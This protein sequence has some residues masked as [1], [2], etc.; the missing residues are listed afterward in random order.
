MPCQ[1]Q[2]DFARVDADPVVPNA[3]QPAAASLEFHLNAPRARVQRIFDELFNHRRGT[4]DNLAG[5]DLINE[6]IGQKLD[7]QWR[8]RRAF[9]HKAL[10]G[11][12]RVGLARW[13]KR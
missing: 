7:G 8:P 2:A 1:R 10:Q 4:F 11:V 12:R 3:N 6:G 5:S 13:P 9:S